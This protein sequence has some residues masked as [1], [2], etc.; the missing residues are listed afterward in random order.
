MDFFELA[1]Q[2]EE[3]SGVK[4]EMAGGLTTWEAF[5]SYRHQDRI[6]IIRQTIRRRTDAIYD[7]A[8]KH[9]SDIYVK[10]PDD[11]IKR[12]DIAIF[13]REPDEDEQDGAV[14]LLPEAIIEIISK[15]YE[16]K[17]LK[18]GVPFFLSQGIR[19]VITLDMV[20][21]TVTHFRPG[22]PEQTYVSPVTLLFACGC[23]ATI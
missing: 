20:T 12:P 3:L 18:V 14:T 22:Q 11:S 8:C 5:P 9:I 2:V 13:C 16:D 19:D 15:R 21:S 6:D 7:C 23:E 17:D 10:F 1:Q 4:L